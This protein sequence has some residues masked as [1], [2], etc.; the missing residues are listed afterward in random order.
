VLSG[1]AALAALAQGGQPDAAFSR[2]LGLAVLQQAAT[3]VLP[4]MVSGPNGLSLGAGMQLL[5]SVSAGQ[6]LCLMTEVDVG[7]LGGG[8]PAGAA[9]AGAVV[10]SGAGGLFEEEAVDGGLFGGVVAQLDEALEQ[11]L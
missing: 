7:A 6:P 5:Q 4:G 11:L 3:S 1:L 8:A 9:A 10:S 2:A